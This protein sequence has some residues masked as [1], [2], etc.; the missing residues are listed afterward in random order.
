MPSLPTE[1]NRLK[2][3]LEGGRGGN[4]H[5]GG[6][7]DLS[8]CYRVSHSNI[9]PYADECWVVYYESIKRKLKTKYIWGV[10]V[11]KD[12]NLT[13]HTDALLKK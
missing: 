13:P 7:L 8:W 10:G 6:G 9:G 12:Y 11:M 2:S 1:E 3:C 4:R 5:S